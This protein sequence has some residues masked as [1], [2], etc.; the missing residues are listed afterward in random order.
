MKK[1]H[2]FFLFWFI[3]ALFFLLSCKK[4]GNLSWNADLSGPIAKANLSIKN[5]LPDSVLITD[6]D[7]ALRI[8]FNETVF[9]FAIDSLV[10]I[11]DTTIDTSYSAPLGGINFTSGQQVFSS[12]A[13]ELNFGINGADISFLQLKKGVIKLEATNSV[14]EAVVLK[15]DLLNTQLSGS[16]FSVV[17]QVPAGSIAQPGSSVAYY[18]IDG[19]SMNLSGISGNKFNTLVTKSTV[20]IDPSANPG[21]INVNEGIGVKLTFMGVIPLYAKGYL[22]SQIF[23][24]ASE[25]V[26]FD[27]FRGI[28]AQQFLLQDANVDLKLSNGFGADVSASGV[29]FTSVNSKTGNNVLLSGNGV[30]SSYNLNRAVFNPASTN[31]VTPGSKIIQLNSSNSNIKQFIENLPDKFSYSTTAQ[32]NPYGNVSGNNDFIYYG[33]GLRADLE[34]NIP[35]AFSAVNLSLLDTVDF[36]FSGFSGAGQIN[37]GKLTLRVNNGYPFNAQIQAFLLNEQQVITDSLFSSPNI[38]LAGNTNAN[39][40]VVNPVLSLLEIPLSPEKIQYLTQAKKIIFKVV[41]NTV[42]QP[43]VV[44]LYEHYNLDFVLTGDINYSVNR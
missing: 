12:P 41:M 44:K 43:Q 6:P 14:S 23:S 5:L 7:S 38:A 21:V 10:A 26:D 29:S 40:I 34:M 20:D 13:T 33:S 18:T 36:D 32:I 31:P 35:L 9:N 27:F 4:E 42:S 39:Q 16:P 2:A 37:G 15:Y 22:G 30:N 17:Q 28:N 24:A 25:T 8:V 1:I 19:L 11:P 3:V